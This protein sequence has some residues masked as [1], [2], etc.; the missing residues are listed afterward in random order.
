M[1]SY[2]SSIRTIVGSEM[3]CCAS[4]KAISVHSPPQACRSVWPSAEREYGGGLL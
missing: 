2:F 1:G 3:P 4:A